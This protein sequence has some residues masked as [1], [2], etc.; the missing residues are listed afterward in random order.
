MLFSTPYILD[1]LFGI[2]I[3]RKGRSAVHSVRHLQAFRE[4]RM[5]RVRDTRD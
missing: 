3:R 4:K 5:V 1:L 2:V